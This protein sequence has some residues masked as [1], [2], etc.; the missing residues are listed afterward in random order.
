MTGYIWSSA[1]ET[2]D[3]PS[4]GKRLDGNWY[5]VK[6]K[7]GGTGGCQKCEMCVAAAT[8]TSRIKA[9]ETGQCPYKKGLSIKRVPPFLQSS[10]RERVVVPVGERWRHWLSVCLP[11]G[12]AGG[13]GTDL[14]RPV[15]V[16]MII[17][18]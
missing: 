18:Q 15:I 10:P 9:V 16:V 13:R 3:N 1:W 11:N 8:D 4:L 7:I 12:L 2:D 17:T 5:C 6:R 14:W